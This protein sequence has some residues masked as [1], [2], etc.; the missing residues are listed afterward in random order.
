MI[1]DGGLFHDMNIGGAIDRCRDLVEDK[2]IIVDILA[3]WKNY[4]Y[5]LRVD[6]IR[7]SDKEAIRLRY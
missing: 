3:S 2:D 7:F 4:L 6:S 5:N 1:G